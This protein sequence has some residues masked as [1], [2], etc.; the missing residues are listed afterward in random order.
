MAKAVYAAKVAS[1]KITFAV[2]GLVLVLSI[3]QRFASPLQIVRTQMI[4]FRTSLI[5]VS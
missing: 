2:D 5:I 3:V 4:S 1:W